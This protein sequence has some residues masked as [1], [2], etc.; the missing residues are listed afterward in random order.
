MRRSSCFLPCCE[1]KESKSELA[2]GTHARIA[3]A[4][5]GSRRAWCVFSVHDYDCGA[6]APETMLRADF[7]IFTG[8]D[9]YDG[10][11][12]RLSYA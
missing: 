9:L 7:T 4:L 1:A 11:R 2:D 10:V 3:K 5:T 6:H 8:T 12:L